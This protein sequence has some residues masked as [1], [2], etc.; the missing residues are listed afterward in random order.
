MTPV[1]P[2][3]TI[4]FWAFI[5]G[6]CVRLK[7]KPDTQ[8]RWYRFERTEEGW[9]SESETWTWNTDEN[10]VE[11]ECESM[12]VDCDGRLDRFR[13][14]VCLVTQLRTGNENYDGDRDMHGDVI[15]F[16]KWLDV[17]HWQ[18]DYSAEAAGY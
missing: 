13:E 18:R 4:R 2:A 8:Y 6:D 15:A 16:P 17:N 10:V 7:L 1:S 11:R 5:N 9:G 14:D 3:K 12:G